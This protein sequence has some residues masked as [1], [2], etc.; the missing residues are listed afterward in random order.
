MKSLP[1]K[2]LF[3]AGCALFFFAPALYAQARVDPSLP[4]APLPEHRALILFP[5][6]ETVYDPD[7]PVPV[8]RP[9]QKFE[10]AWRKTFDPSYVIGAGI[11]TAVDEMFLV[12]PRYNGGP[13][14]VAQLYGYNAANL[15]S[16]F[17]FT[18]GLLPVV[19]HQD[20]RYFRKARGSKTSRVWWAL[21]SQFVAVNDQGRPMPNYSQTLGFAMSTALSNAYLPPQNVSFGH[22]MEGI[23]IKETVRFGTDLVRE[24]GAVDL[25]KKHV[26]G[27]Q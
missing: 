8:L 17:F 12:G 18:D 15:A 1:T 19:F 2:A 7:T 21:R 22:T 14:G 4:E 20:P 26:L 16:T 3:C 25:F 6:Y 27:Q 13:K 24:F 9:H 10:M 23:G 11:D 5:G